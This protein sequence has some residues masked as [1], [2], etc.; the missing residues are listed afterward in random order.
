MLV[1]GL[2]KQCDVLPRVPRAEHA[3]SGQTLVRGKESGPLEFN[4]ASWAYTAFGGDQG[5][6]E[7]MN[8][9]IDFCW[10]RDGA[11]DLLT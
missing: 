2:L 3:F 8:L 9:A 7:S 5:I 1:S 10:I 6:A 4:L 11:S